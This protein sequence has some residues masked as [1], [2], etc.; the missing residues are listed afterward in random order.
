MWNL[1]YLSHLT[2]GK[3]AKLP[4]KQLIAPPL[5]H[6]RADYQSSSET[7]LLNKSAVPFFLVFLSSIVDCRQQCCSHPVA[8]FGAAPALA[9]SIEKESLTGHYKKKNNGGRHFS[10]QHLPCGGEDSLK[11][12]PV[13]N[14]GRQQVLTMCEFMNLMAG[15]ESSEQCWPRN[16]FFASRQW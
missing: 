7:R 3:E 12:P 8:S 9:F 1:R 5:S 13:C 14:N 11:L 6:H 15:Y 16:N 2:P 10:L 4:E